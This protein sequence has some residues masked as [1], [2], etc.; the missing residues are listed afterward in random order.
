MLS[1]KLNLMGAA[2]M[3]GL[4]FSVDCATQAPEKAETPATTTE[5]PATTTPVT[6][7]ETL[8]TPADLAAATARFNKRVAAY[9]EEL[10]LRDVKAN[11]VVD[12]ILDV[13]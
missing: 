12:F 9:S 13:Y 3:A 6:Q 4:L 5:T 10:I 7:A 8:A 11:I 1:L 2:A